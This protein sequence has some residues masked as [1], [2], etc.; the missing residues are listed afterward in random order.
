MVK[1]ILIGAKMIELKRDKLFF[2]FP[3]VH[4]DARLEITFHRTLRIPDDGD[5]YP[6]PP[7]LGSFPLR[8]VDDFAKNVPKKW[9]EHGGVMLPMYQ[10]EALWISFESKYL[11][12]HRTEY[13]FAIKIATGKVNAV[14]GTTWINTLSGNPQ[15]YVVIPQQPWLDG[16]CVEKKTYQAICRNA[17]WSR[18]FR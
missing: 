4:P 11:D 17:A 1:I 12:R 10:S 2:T 15:D 7:G 3:E 13:P 18:I 5:T 14:T 16:Y 6:L 8:H 9:V